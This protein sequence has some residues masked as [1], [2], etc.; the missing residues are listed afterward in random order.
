[1][2]KSNAQYTI[3]LDI[4]GTNMR[5]VLYD[6]AKAVTDDSLG[7]PQDNLNHFLIM[8]KALV[9]PMLEKAG[10]SKAKV[11]GVGIGIPGEIEKKTGKLFGAPNLPIIEN[12]PMIADKI[13]AM[14]GLP[15]FL[16]NDANVFL[17]GEVAAG[18]AK[19]FKSVYALTIGTGIGGAWWVNGGIFASAYGGANEPG[20]M[21]IDS[22]SGLDFERS[23]QKLTQNNPGQLAEETYRG[24]L[25]GEKAFEE[26]G[27]SLGFVMA[28]IVNI[29]DPEA[30]VLGGSVIKSSNLFLP[31]AKKVMKEHI[32]FDPSARQVKVMKSKLGPLAGAIGAALLV[33]ERGT[34]SAE[35]A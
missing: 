13:S 34:Q 3:G 10:E 23:F 25:L 26:F 5:A 8:I 9:D 31:M 20:H 29:I 18:A 2:K 22:A 11:S 1:M 17:R 30:F 15:V 19:E 14:I 4:G 16:D 35:R 12:V 27:R 28:N 7:T 33:A 32:I 24:D 21:M 6:G